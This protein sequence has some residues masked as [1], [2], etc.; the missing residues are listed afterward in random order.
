MH[1]GLRT[2]AITKAHNEHIVLRYAGYLV[3]GMERDGSNP[4]ESDPFDDRCVKK[5]VFKRSNSLVNFHRTYLE[6]FTE[7]LLVIGCQFAYL[8]AI[9]SPKSQANYQWPDSTS[10]YS[11]KFVTT[12]PSFASKSK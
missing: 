6:V 11:A 8:E 10:H 5:M 1:N 4:R 9:A 2:K 7:I 3:A 12:N